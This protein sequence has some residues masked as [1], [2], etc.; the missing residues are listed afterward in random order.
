M[1]ARKLRVKIVNVGLDL[2]AAE[3]W[4]ALEVAGFNR[5]ELIRRFIKAHGRELLSS[6]R[7]KEVAQNG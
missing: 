4:E 2:E 3:I 6:S 5:T 7:Q 1:S